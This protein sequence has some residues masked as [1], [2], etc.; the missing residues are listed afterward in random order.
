MCP[1]LCLGTKHSVEQVGQRNSKTAKLLVCSFFSAG[2]SQ[3]Q[4]SQ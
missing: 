2:D 3:A 1:E 4:G